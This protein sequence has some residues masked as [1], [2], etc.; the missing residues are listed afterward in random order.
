VTET[1]FLE[2]LRALPLHPAALGLR[3]DAAHLGRLILTTD[4]IVEGVHFLATDPAQDVALKL[5]ATNLSDLAA[6]GATPVGVL[7]NYPL[8]TDAAWDGAFLE[9]LHEA[10]TTFATPLLGGDTVSL[11]ANAPRVLTI[12]AIG[13]SATATARSGAKAA[14]PSTSPA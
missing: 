2:R 3:D 8:T 4:T 11:P 1:E 9:G 5:V 14:T 7:L 10:L 12:T 6:K 13:D